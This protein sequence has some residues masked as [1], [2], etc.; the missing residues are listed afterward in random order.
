MKS[1]Y[2]TLQERFISLSARHVGKGVVVTI[3][4]VAFAVH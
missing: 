2:H 4:L 3:A 1:I